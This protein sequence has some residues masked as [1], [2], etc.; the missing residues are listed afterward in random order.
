MTGAERTER[1]HVEAAFVICLETAKLT[2]TEFR[3]SNPTNSAGGFLRQKKSEPTAVA[4]CGQRP[5]IDGKIGGPDQE[6]SLGTLRG[7]L[8]CLL[9]HLGCYW[10][11]K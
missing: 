1:H 6:G 10:L 5:R 9:V 3:K 7:V 2:I 8:S 11:N 4:E